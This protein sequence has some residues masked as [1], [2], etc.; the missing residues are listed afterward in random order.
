MRVLVTGTEGYIGS[1]LGPMLAKGGHDVVGI[2]AGFYRTRPLYDLDAAAPAD[3]PG[4]H[5]NDRRRAARGL[6]AVVHLAEL[7]NDPLGQLAPTHH[8]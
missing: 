1:L 2:D 6:D 3:A 4:G 5:P 7:S 8:L